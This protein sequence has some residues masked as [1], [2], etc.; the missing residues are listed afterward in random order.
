MVEDESEY[1]EDEDDVV[2]VFT[3]EG[4]FGGSGGAVDDS[5]DEDYVG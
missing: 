1:H 2:N 3:C 4:D 5:D